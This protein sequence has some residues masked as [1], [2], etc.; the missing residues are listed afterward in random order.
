MVAMDYIARRTSSANAPDGSSIVGGNSIIISAEDGS[1]D[2]LVPRLDAAGTDWARHKVLRVTATR[3]RMGERMFSLRRDLAE[4]EKLIL[5]KGADLVVIDPL[6]AYLGEGVNAWSDS[7]LRGLLTPLAALAERLSVAVWGI[8]HFTK[9][10]DRT[11][12]LRIA[13]SIAFAA[14]ARVITAV[15]ED[16]NDRNRRFLMG[17]KNNVGK[18][19]ETLAFKIMS[20][21]DGA[22]VLAWER[23]P[24]ADAPDIDTI[25]AAKPSDASAKRRAVE[26]LREVFHGHED[27]ALPAN[28]VEAAAE[29]KGISHATLVRAR[30]ELGITSYHVGG[31]DGAWVWRM[32]PLNSLGGGASAERESHISDEMNSL[33]SS[34]PKSASPRK[35][36]KNPRVHRDGSK[37]PAP[38]VK[39]TA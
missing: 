7:D 32:K 4:M 19:A 29:A 23:E 24:V 8:L 10:A 36:S 25:L 13:G 39:A 20:S 33:I 34:A 37:S 1:A 11:A 9:S 26:F 12:I 2:T 3:S 31:S 27:E 38:P 15:V 21:P 17:I 5:A 30:G 6:S 14:A 28:E 16:P 18:K 22:P 35:R